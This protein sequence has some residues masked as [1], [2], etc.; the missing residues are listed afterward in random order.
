M[1]QLWSGIPV[2]SYT[3]HLEDVLFLNN[4][5]DKFNVRQ[6]NFVY[7]SFCNFSNNILQGSHH[8]VNFNREG[9]R[10]TKKGQRQ[11]QFELW[12][13]YPDKGDCMHLEN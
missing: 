8:M 9:Q 5:I 12:R 2:P 7:P 11:H 3:N 4:E 10:T 1:P 6:V 13:E